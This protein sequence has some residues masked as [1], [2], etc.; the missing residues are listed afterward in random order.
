MHIRPLAPWLIAFAIA[1][2]TRAVV[3]V[4]EV[5]PEGEFKVRFVGP[6]VGNRIAAVAGIAG[7]ASTYYAGAA[8]GG[9]WKSTD[10]G[11]RW[12]P[13][14]DKQSAAAIGAL[15]IAPSQP[16]TVWA[17][18]GEAWVIRDTDVMGNGI[19]K[20]TDAGRTWTHMG[21][22][23]SGR[24]GRIVVHPSDPDIVFACVLGRATGAQQER[25]VY[26]TS[27]AGQHWT[28]VL[29]AGEDTGCSGLSMD[30]HDPHTL[31]AGMWQVEMHTWGEYSGGPHSGIYISHDGG[32][33]WTRLEG[34]GLP[35]APLGKID[36]A[37]APTNSNRI[38]ALI[39]TK[40]Q[41]SLWRS[42][43]A[44]ENWQRV[45]SQ[46][47]LIG[48]AG[49]YIRLA[50]S[51]GSDNEVYVANSSFHR[52]LDWGESFH[53][54][55]WGGDTH[56]IWIDPA[57][58]DR[59]VITDDGGMIITTVH[60][61]GFHRVTLPIG[62]MYHVAVDDQIPYYFYSNMQDDGNMRGPS[63]AVDSEETG[64]DRHMGGCESGFTIP[65]PSDPNIVWATCYGDT[66]TRWDA[67]YREAH[68]VSPWKHT[69]DSPPNAVKYRCHWTP[70]LAIDPFDHNAVYY[71]CQVIFRTSD[72][73]RSWSVVSPDLSRAD[74]AHLQ[75]SGGIVG[76]NLGQF[77]GAVVFAIAAS[78]IQ[79]GLIWA[80]TNDGQVW[81]SRDGAAS[82]INVTSNVTGLPAGGTI[83]SIAPSSFEPGSA[84]L[85][86]DFHLLDN[87]DP[88]IYRTR[89]FGRSWTRIN[90][91]LPKHALSYV[92]SI[93]D[94]PNCP[95]LLFA[96]TGNGLYYSLD[97]GARWRPLQ[98]GLP[99]APV[100]W[101]V[102]QK[103]FHDLVLST[104][105]R[106]LYILDDITPLEQ[107]ARAGA[108]APV[109][110]FEPRKTYRFVR[111]GQALLNYSLAAVPKGKVEL[112]IL[113]SG[114]KRVRTLEGKGL[115]GI[116][117]IEWDLRYESPR[118]VALRTV[119]PDNPRI[120]QEP[121]FR[122]AESRPITHWGSKPAEVGPIAAPG[123]YTVRLTVDGQ[124]YAQSLTLLRD[125]RAPGTEADLQ[126]SVQ[127][128]LQIRDDIS[129]VSDLV[130]ELEW[131]RKQLEVIQTMLRPA[132]P[133]EKPKP[134]PREGDDEEEPEPPAA[135]PRVLSEV[136]EQQRV[137]LLAAA[138][139]L[140]NKLQTL[141]AQLVSRALRNSDD[142]YFVEANGVYL[143]LVWLNAEVGTGGGDVAGG[144]DFAPT[145]AQLETLRTLQAEMASIE[146]QYREI[147]QKD[148]PA[149]NQALSRADLTPLLTQQPAR[150]GLA[151]PG[152][153]YLSKLH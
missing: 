112:E 79:Q 48:R 2:A 68:S 32:T 98:N 24:I 9:V 66:V 39:Q 64:W 123:T 142:K 38:Y 110:L 31:I 120:W 149:F 72:A 37:I 25:G 114:G 34:K 73:G 101:V 15:A 1:T 125:P 46:R 128:L 56:D 77:Y 118:V 10:G 8:S 96:G 41:G 33:R 144:A 29:F 138:R 89:D 134:H 153:T 147:L 67:R 109:V 27:D 94:D 50:V 105:G 75:P 12:Q 11:N 14:F 58:P 36:V 127:T 150:P 81:Y 122:E 76:D 115:V 108:A 152:R 42:D 143:D 63:L 100:S 104:Y 103:E 126:L 113:D 49:Y 21:L 121:R 60:G 132:A 146:A 7:D 44:G 43:D 90:S 139:N 133:P 99:P 87:R 22:A 92:R 51:T 74:P 59:F 65:D 4:P 80:G 26:R 102:V 85:S 148:L 69:L 52:S 78:K 107:L 28:R 136:E 145:A 91:N 16:G 95:G 117:R 106:G 45:N 124:R 119:A 23:D 93:T 141:E 30:A 17:G 5:S 130:N 54:L 53:E 82:W 19:Y 111:G 140:D 47:A 20:S 35:N 61:R 137:Q 88:F 135:P 13:I 151:A 129:R 83:T 116:N 71:G 97:D 3:P 62:Q 6:N 57:N 86:V 84:Y 131:L 70:P 18:T 55:R 40:D